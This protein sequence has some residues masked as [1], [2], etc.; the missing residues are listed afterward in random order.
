MS[1]EKSIMSKAVIAKKGP[2]VVELEPGDYRYY[3][4]DRSAEQPSCD[5]THK[6]L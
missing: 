3:A 1:S 6:P 5:G 4:C 2:F